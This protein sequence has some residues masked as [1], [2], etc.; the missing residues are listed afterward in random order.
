MISFFFPHRAQLSGGQKQRI[1]IARSLLGKPKILLLDEATSALDMR[2]ETIVQAALDRAVKGRTTVIVAHRLSTIRNAHRIVYLDKGQV[3]EQGSHEELMAKKGA[4]Y[5]LVAGQQVNT[6]SKTKVAAVKA[7]IAAPA[8]KTISDKKSPSLG[9]R[10]SYIEMQKAKD[11][12][13]RLLRETPFPWCRLLGM[14]WEDKCCF[15]WGVFGAFVFGALTPAYAVVFGRFVDALVTRQARQKTLDEVK[16]CAIYYALIAI[17]AFVTTSA[18]IS[19]FGYIGEHLTYR[20]RMAAYRAL[21]SKSIAY[22]DRD[23]NSS[24]TLCS[25]LAD[26]ASNIQEATGARIS[27]F[28]QA[29]SSLLIALAISFYYNW[30]MALVCLGLIPFIIIS[31]V[32]SGGLQMKQA[33]Q[34]SNAAAMASKLAIEVLNNIRTVVSLHKERY[35]L[36]KFL[37]DLVANFRQIVRDVYLKSGIIAI[38]MGIPFFVFLIALLFGSHLVSKR[39]ITTGDFFTIV[40]A[41][42]FGSL[43]IGQAAVMSSSMAVAKLATLKIFMLVDDKSDKDMPEELTTISTPANKRCRGELTFSQTEFYYPNRPEIRILSGLSFS[44]KVGETVALV[45]ES[46]CGKSTW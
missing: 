28:F 38:S 20:M 24:G 42:L 8:V 1:S 27:M 41:M 32:Y 19:L 23:E 29:I 17:G 9:R 6:E 14:L 40:Q 5:N 2:S 12:S 30:Q 33:G 34:D 16:I 26:D 37:V 45:G 36:N 44:A 11:E 13:E 35:F 46:G 21:M 39:L 22:F 4:Y 31:A 18:Q 43:V 25:R 15:I 7:P 3:L 10:K